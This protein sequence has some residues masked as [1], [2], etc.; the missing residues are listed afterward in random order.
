MTKHL[1]E[2]PR[3]FAIRVTLSNLKT[4]EEIDWFEDYQDEQHWAEMEFEHLS[5][6]HKT[7][8]YQVSKRFLCN[9]ENELKGL[10]CFRDGSKSNTSQ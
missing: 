10:D 4:G 5:N 2:S 8:N 9:G 3:N 7:F 1:P 6:A